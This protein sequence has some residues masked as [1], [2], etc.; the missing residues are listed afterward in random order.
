MLQTKKAT[1]RTVLADG[2]TLALIL[3]KAEPLLFSKPDGEQWANQIRS[4]AA[5]KKD[6][7]NITV[8]L[9]TTE[10]VDAAGKRL[11]P[12]TR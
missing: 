12:N 5:E 4:T 10:M 6:D 11:H 3:P 1:A 2:Q 9:V 7:E 8:V